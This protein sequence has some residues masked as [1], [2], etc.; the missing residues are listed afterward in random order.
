M[1]FKTF[2]QRAATVVALAWA[3]QAAGAAPPPHDKT[4]T[5]A[6]DGEGRAK[7]DVPSPEPGREPGAHPIV[8]IAEAY[9]VAKAGP[10]TPVKFGAVRTLATGYQQADTPSWL[11]QFAGRQEPSVLFADN[12]RRQLFRCVPGTAPDLVSAEAGRGRIGPDG[13]T[14]YGLHGGKLA[15]W[16]L[17]KADAKPTILCEKTA[18]GR[19]LSI[20][21][22]AI[23]SRGIVYFTTLKDPDKGRLSTFDPRTGKVTVLFDDLDKGK[24][25]RWLPLKTDGI[26]VRDNGDV[27]VTAEDRIQACDVYGRSLG[28]VKIPKGSGTNLCVG[29]RSA[30][31]TT[32]FFTT[33]DTLY[34]VDVE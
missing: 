5:V 28:N 13:G 1:L 17:A 14:F 33:W 19:D 11:G 3:S 4:F 25:D 9:P 24:Q 16:P 26:A 10:V 30:N 29:P 31:A 15:A 8:T 18:D 7:N 34:S 32:L 12:K 6:N 2:T 23:S 22:L 27:F 21:D 20:N